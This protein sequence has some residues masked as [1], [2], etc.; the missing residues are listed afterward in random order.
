M[1]RKFWLVWNEQGNN[2]RYKHETEGSARAEAER[3][4]KSHGGR[5]HV[6]ELVASCERNEVIWHETSKAHDS[7]SQKAR[8]FS[9]YLRE[10]NA[11]AD[12]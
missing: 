9:D 1:N 12:E 8:T 4:T 10:S 3:L 6:L 2:P 7:E 5:F 11:D